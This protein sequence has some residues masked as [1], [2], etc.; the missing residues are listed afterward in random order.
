MSRRPGTIREVLDVDIPGERN[1]EMMVKP[2]FLELKRK[3]MDMLWQESQE[4]AM[5]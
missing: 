2:E 3:I 4:A 5:E 1:H